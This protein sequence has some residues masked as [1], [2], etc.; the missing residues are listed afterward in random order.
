MEGGGGAKGKESLLLC[1]HLP[2]SFSQNVGIL[3]RNQDQTKGRKVR[4]KQRGI[5]FC[6]LIFIQV[7]IYLSSLVIKVR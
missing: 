4:R 3:E 6:F 2:T 5:L 1:P 7:F